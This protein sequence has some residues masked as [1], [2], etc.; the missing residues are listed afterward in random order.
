[1]DSEVHGVK[2]GP[3]GFMASLDH[4]ATFNADRDPFK[5]HPEMLE[6]FERLYEEEKRTGTPFSKFASL[7][8]QFSW[9]K[10]DANGKRNSQIKMWFANRRRK[11]GAKAANLGQNAFMSKPASSRREL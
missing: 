8:E 5:D 4:F 11:D 1:M 2:A 7:H 10:K 3:D 9:P 6:E